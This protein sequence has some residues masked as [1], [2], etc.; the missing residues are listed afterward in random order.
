MYNLYIR[1]LYIVK[2]KGKINIDSC[3]GEVHTRNLELEE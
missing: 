1:K 2:V 3:R